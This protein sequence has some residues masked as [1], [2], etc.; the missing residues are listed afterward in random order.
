MEVGDDKNRTTP[1]VVDDGRT[2]FPRRG[3]REPYSID[4]RPPSCRYS[5]VRRVAGNEEDAKIP[6]SFDV[7]RPQ[8]INLLHRL[9]SRFSFPRLC[10]SVPPLLVR[11]E[12]ELMDSRSFQLG[13]Y[14]FIYIPSR[15]II[16]LERSMD[17]LLV[18]QRL[19]SLPIRPF[20]LLRLMIAL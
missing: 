17:I 11:P 20:W 1:C 7:E 18:Y 16:S 15:T 19:L 8:E 13:I 12:E 9:Q 5:T 4:F 2:D 3:S 6:P 14:Q 10:L